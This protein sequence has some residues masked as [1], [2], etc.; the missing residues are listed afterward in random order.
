MNGMNRELYLLKQV[1]IPISMV[2]K[3]IATLEE[4]LKSLQLASPIFTGS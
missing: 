2:Q 1:Q 4:R 3:R